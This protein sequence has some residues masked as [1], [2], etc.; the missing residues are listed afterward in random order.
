MALWD[1]SAAGPLAG[2]LMSATLLGL[3]LAQSAGV[4]GQL[5]P[6]ALVPVPSALFQGSLL[7]GR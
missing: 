2:G 1:V 5:P 3:G 4:G 6:E 7:L